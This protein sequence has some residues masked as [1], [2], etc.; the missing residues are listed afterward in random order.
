MLLTRMFL[1][2]IVL[3]SIIL[4]LSLVAARVMRQ[5]ILD[6]LGV[7]SEK[8]RIVEEIRRMDFMKDLLK[9]F[10]DSESS[11][12]ALTI[13]ETALSNS[14]QVP[15]LVVP[16][17]AMKEIEKLYSSMKM[18]SSSS[19][20]L[21]KL[22]YTSNLF[23]KIMIVYGILLASIVIF[24]ALFAGM[25]NTLGLYNLAGALFIA[26]ALV[27]SAI[28]VYLLLNVRSLSRRATLDDL[29]SFAKPDNNY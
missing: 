4:G 20:E 19:I 23:V 16:Q 14:N 15:N 13:L 29:K 6:S 8:V 2:D 12:T 27:F 18:S 22:E 9:F 1:I 26:V 25:I 24:L 5:N 7:L 11:K 10:S 3:I 28:L 21:A 17:E